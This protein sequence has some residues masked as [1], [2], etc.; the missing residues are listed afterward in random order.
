MTQTRPELCHRRTRRIN[1]FGALINLAQHFFS[2]GSSRTRMKML[3]QPEARNF[4]VCF[5]NDS[6]GA[7]FDW[8]CVPFEWK[9]C[10]SRKFRVVNQ[11]FS[12]FFQ[13]KSLGPAKV[14]LFGCISPPLSWLSSIMIT[15][16]I[17]RGSERRRK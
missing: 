1:G 7:G 16:G 5:E 15:S 6:A 9:L 8:L 3:M 13:Q 17:W 14:L 11:S 2:R 12:R 4:H 10:R